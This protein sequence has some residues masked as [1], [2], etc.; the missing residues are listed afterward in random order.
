MGRV[1]SVIC[2]ISYVVELSLVI[3]TLGLLEAVGWQLLLGLLIGSMLLCNIIS[4]VRVSQTFN[5]YREPCNLLICLVLHLFQLG[6]IWRFCKLVKPFNRKHSRDL[7]KIQLVH[8][9][10]LSVPV[11]LYMSHLY[12]QGGAVEHVYVAVITA[13]FLS[14]VLTLSYF[15]N[16][17]CKDET[18]YGVWL[19][20]IMWRSCMLFAR[21][22]ALIWAL[23][24]PESL[25]A[26]L[27]LVAHF[28]ILMIWYQVHDQSK[29]DNCSGFR[30][31][32]I[33]LS[34]ANTLDLTISEYK[35][36]ME[37][38]VGFFALVLGENITLVGIWYWSVSQPDGL[39]HTM[40][41]VTA[42]ASYSA[43]LLLSLAAMS[44]SAREKK[45]L[46]QR[47]FNRLCQCAQ[48][49]NDDSHLAWDAYDT[50]KPRSTG[51]TNQAYNVEERQKHVD[52]MNNPLG[53]NDVASLSTV[54][55]SHPTS[56]IEV[57]VDSP[58]C[59]DHLKRPWA[60]DKQ[61]TGKL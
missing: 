13:S 33:V 5:F 22:S 52:I 27:I 23:R 54:T 37:W 55:P 17:Q 12:L 58:S 19:C 35:V 53:V 15:S 24:S 50:D 4:A 36:S 49:G 3:Y 42:F 18:D 45:T 31:W 26:G 28:L 60:C 47:I 40:W 44:L 9:F 56:P 51:H 7:M 43:G 14:T 1:Q 11:V 29:G 8:N 41:L 32:L 20:T 25:W 30:V 59:T 34:L 57:V 6:I 39:M 61:V 16:F 48:A 46:F 38:F 10:I 2:A 21:F